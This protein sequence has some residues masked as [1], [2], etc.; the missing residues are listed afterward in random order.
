MFTSD[1]IG[2]E[3][4]GSEGWKIGKVTEVAIDREKWVITGLTVSLESNVA[5]EFNLKKTWGKSDFTIPIGHVQGV[6]DRIILRISKTE[7][8][9]IAQ[10][11]EK[12]SERSQIVKEAPLQ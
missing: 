12:K 6:G 5:K 3:V 10:T 11:E 7:V 8:F 9:N 4:V 1:L 2:K